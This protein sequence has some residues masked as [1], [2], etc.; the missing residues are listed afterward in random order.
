MR[1]AFSNPIPSWKVQSCFDHHVPPSPTIQ[2]Y[3][4]A[5]LPCSLTD[6][7]RELAT[8]AT[9]TDD[10][11][12]MEELEDIYG[13]IDDDIARIQQ[14]HKTRTSSADNDNDDNHD[15]DVEMVLFSYFCDHFT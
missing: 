9:T 2:R 10:H 6:A 5:V 1:R 13:G 12:S 3:R 4:A 7:E 14:C 15:E 8:S 11:P